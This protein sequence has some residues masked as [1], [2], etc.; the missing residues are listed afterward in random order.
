MNRVIQFVLKATDQ[1][2]AVFGKVSGAA[3]K[4]GASFKTIGAQLKSDINSMAG[5]W[6][7]FG[8][9]AGILKSVNDVTNDY[10]ASLRK[11]EGTAKIAGVPLGFLQS[12]AAQARS[13][14]GLSAVAANDLTT[15]VAKLAAKSGDIS[16]AGDLLGRFLD[17][18]AA[19]G[20]SAADTLQ[21]VRQS[22][23][24]I[25]EGTDK[26]FGA[27]PSVLYERFATAI[28]TTAGKL[29][30][31]QKA[32]ALVTATMEDGGKVVGAYSDYLNSAAGK[33]EQAKQKWQEA[34]ITLGQALAPALNVAAA[35]VGVLGQAIDWLIKSWE[36]FWTDLGF[37]TSAIGPTFEKLAGHVVQFLGD[38]FDKLRDLPLVGD[39]FGKIADTLQDKGG[40]MVQYNR[41]F[42][43]ELRG[44]YQSTSQAIWNTTT[45]TWDGV[46]QATQ[47][48]GKKV[49]EEAKKQAEAVQKELLGT[50]SE[51]SQAWAR[52]W[53][54]QTSAFEKEQA[55]RTAILKKATPEQARLLTDAW[56]QMDE[57][58]T[59]LAHG[60]DRVVVPA[61]KRTTEQLRD[62]KPPADN[63]DDAVR[64][65]A[66]GYVY[67]HGK[68][69]K[70][71]AAADD[72][73]QK[74]GEALDTVGQAAGAVGDFAGG[75][76]L[77]DEKAAGAI[78]SVGNLA[79]NVGRLLGGTLTTGGMIGAITAAA[80][81]VV[82]IFGAIFGSGADKAREAAHRK[83]LD[84]NT[85]AIRSNTRRI[86]DLLGLNVSGMTFAKLTGTVEGL[87]GLA[88]QRGPGA[89]TMQAV[90]AALQDVGLGWSDLEQILR[91]SGIKLFD[92]Q[93]RPIA[94]AIQQ[95]LQWL[96]ATEPTQFAR[97]WQGLLSQMD[98]A[99]SIGA[100]SADREL[101]HF[102]GILTQQGTF[103][104][105]ILEN[106][107]L[108]TEDGRQALLDYLQSLP[109][110]LASG[111]L[112]PWQ[113]G[114]LTGDQFLEA[115]QTLFGLLTDDVADLFGAG[116]GDGDGPT[117][118]FPP[119]LTAS[120]IGLPDLG[121]QQVDYLGSIDLGIGRLADALTT[122]V[123]ADTGRLVDVAGR[124][125]VHLG[126]VAVT[127][128]VQQAVDAPAVVGDL[129]V[130]AIDDALAA[131][132]RDQQLA[133][134][135]L[136]RSV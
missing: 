15:E 123:D 76:G 64:R 77:V 132:Y 114:D 37:A 111:Q 122:W 23:L 32:L 96:Q 68:W 49:T 42:L 84:D 135:G 80:G 100:L 39:V 73:R 67:L 91:Q 48:G 18:G 136:S 69:V 41:V 119:D 131:R 7:S 28:G 134:G 44:E 92:D 55:R 110:L 17:L 101:E 125:G 121:Q 78:Q 94:G 93:N 60:F 34:A 113:L 103:L 38:M 116:G 50:A 71:N 14:F 98:F 66:D 45:A 102:I 83:V 130:A 105:G 117:V 56:R 35:A 26:L 20:L 70:A 106:A 128:N 25:D 79:D 75:L 74:F 11:L 31:Q 127:V 129:V 59:L 10:N 95:L 33:Q 65:L 97:D 3:G 52:I 82:G 36:Q 108:T 51:T 62:L 1:A 57:A 12:V 133:A 24:G 118:Q 40:K 81:A 43:E 58:N 53:G 99:K 4:M 19:K 6:L 9:V 90:L 29:S 16:K 30:D 124:G 112:E 126:G 21:A 107:D 63:L 89:V 87:A 8:A 13:T 54:Q 2:T 5:R 109:E 85:E 47:T 120:L 27:N 72:S 115:V 61:L 86:G 104:N 46:L 22:I 88:S